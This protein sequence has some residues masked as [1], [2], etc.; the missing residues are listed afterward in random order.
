MDLRELLLVLFQNMEEK[1]HLNAFSHIFKNQ[2]LEDAKRVQ[3]KILDGTEGK[4][5][6]AFIAIKDNICIKGYQ[7]S[8]ASPALKDYKADFDAT[9]VSR[10][11]EEDAIIVGMTN[12]DEFAM[13]SSNERSGYGPVLHPM[14]ADRVPGGSSG[15]SAVAVAA[16]LC[17]AALGTDTGGSIRQPAVYC[18]ISALKPTFGRVSRYGCIAYAPSFDQIGP[19]AADIATL[20]DVLN[21][22]SGLDKNDATSWENSQAAD[23]KPQKVLVVNFD[24]KAESWDK[25][26]DTIFENLKGEVELSEKQVEYEDKFMP[27][28]HILTMVEASSSMARYQNIFFGQ[29]NDDD[30]S[31][32][33]YRTQELGWEVQRKIMAGIMTM[34]EDSQRFQ[35]A[36]HWRRIISDY[37]ED[38]TE[39]YD[40]LML[41]ATPSA[42]LRKDQTNDF[43]DLYK[44]DKFLLPANLSGLP[45]M[46]V[47]F[48]QNKDKMPVAVQIMAGRNREYLLIKFAKRLNKIYEIS[49]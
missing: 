38:L 42:A 25:I 40:L 15:G 27:A 12:C 18:G 20:A 22:I 29:N 39:Q 13:G 30:Y 45:S 2:A 23:A 26:K 21:V 10:L 41:P 48:E 35:N 4:L 8:A 3:N 5:A 43:I 11:R 17:H 6:G 36:L 46:V 47:P 1:K 7:T 33:N 24:E 19:M 9:V 37:F 44:H 16:G 34:C 31:V 14:D 28:Y 49:K 32:N